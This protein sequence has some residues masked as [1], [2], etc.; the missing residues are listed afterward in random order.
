ME[1][2]NKVADTTAKKVDDV[3][4]EDSVFEVLQ[5]TKP[6]SKTIIMSKPKTDRFQ[7]KIYY[8]RSKKIME[9]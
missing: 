4:I 2:N 9:I 6:I 7:H 8:K 3:S 5:K 1:E